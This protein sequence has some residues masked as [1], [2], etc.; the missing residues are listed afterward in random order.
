MH[1]AEATLERTVLEDGVRARQTVRR[2]DHRRGFMR[3]VRRRQASG[4][5]L[6]HAQHSIAADRLP[7]LRQR[8][9]QIPLRRAEPRVRDSHRGLDGGVLADGALHTPRDLASREIY[10]RPETRMGEPEPD[11]AERRAEHAVVR[12]QVERTLLAPIVGRIA[13]DVRGRHAHVGTAERLA[14]SAT[15]PAHLP[16]VVDRHATLRQQHQALRVSAIGFEPRTAIRR[17]HVANR[18]E[19]AGVADATREHPAARHAVAVGGLHRAPGPI[20]FARSVGEDRAL[21]RE[22]RADGRR[23]SIRCVTAQ[24]IRLA[25]APGD[26]A[27]RPSQLLDGTRERR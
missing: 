22:E 1:V 4:D 25:D 23:I 27:I 9:L 26:A 11:G 13:N 8:V 14:A 6:I 12:K 20:A 24:A 5:L 21:V 7:H 10:Q 2:V 3:R 15:Q 17:I 16:D 18:Q 19:P